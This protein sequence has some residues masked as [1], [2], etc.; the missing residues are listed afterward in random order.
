MKKSLL[1]PMAVAIALSACAETET[2]NSEVDPLTAALSGKTLVAD[3]NVFNVEKNGA[4][5]GTLSDGTKFVG[6][7]EVVDGKWCN[8][9]SEPDGFAETFCGNAVFEGDGTV[10][11]DRRAGG[12]LNWTIQ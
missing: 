8:S 11:L 7:W 12:T 1:L 6:V 10:T 3:E 5:T 9:F 4:L 2:T